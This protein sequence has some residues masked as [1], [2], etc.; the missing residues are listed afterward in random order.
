MRRSYSL[1]VLLLVTAIAAMSLASLRLLW[2]RVD[3]GAPSEIAMPMLAGAIGGGAFGVALAIWRGAAWVWTLL[4]L[5]GGLGL[6]AAAG[7]QLTA[8]VSWGVVVLC[9][10]IVLAA[11]AVVAL[12]SRRRELIRQR[13][14][15]REISPFAEHE[16][17]QG[18]S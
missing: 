1:A 11:T 10:L 6:G 3:A 15:R 2:L 18:A 13:E 7:A 17:G 9:P 8:P 16:A 5:V 4:A 12:N 14:S